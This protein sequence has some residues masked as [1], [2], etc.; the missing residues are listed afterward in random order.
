MPHLYTTGEVAKKLNIEVRKLKYFA[1]EG[2][3]TPSQIRQSGKKSSRLYSEVDIVKIRQLQLYQ[4]LGYS[5]AKIK[6]LL[7]SPD[8]DW[9]VAVGEQIADLKVKKRHIENS[10]L[11][12]ELMRSVSVQ[13]ES[14][15]PFDISDF[16]NDIDQFASGLFESDLGSSPS[17]GLKAM[18]S[19]IAESLSVSEMNK[20]GEVIINMLLSLRDSLLADPSSDEVQTKLSEFFDYLGAVSNY[21]VFDPNSILLGLRIVSTLSIEWTMDMLLAKEGATE[22]LLNALQTYCDRVK[23]VDENG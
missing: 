12:L 1:E 2:L 3:I 6:N 11:V 15:M 23:E 5:N 4:D 14:A 9:R 20:Q 13:D 19:D 18:N 10:I 17:Q 21:P 8:F 22:L 7:S 16:D